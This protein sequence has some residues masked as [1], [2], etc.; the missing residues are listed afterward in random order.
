MRDEPTEG[1]APRSTPANA[2]FTPGMIAAAAAITLAPFVVQTATI[3]L[4]RSI[5]ATGIVAAALALAF[6][7]GGIA[8]QARMAGSL[9]AVSA[10]SIVGVVLGVVAYHLLALP[11][12]WIL[13]IKLFP[14]P[15]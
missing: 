11:V 5:L 9:R 2:R 6:I 13:Y 4:T 14:P 7:A 1:S 8:M 3:A 10:G 12:A 15:S